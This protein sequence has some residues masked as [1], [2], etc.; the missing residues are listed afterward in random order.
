[1]QILSL[2]KNLN[3]VILCDYGFSHEWMSFVCWY[4][5]SKN[6]PDAS[7]TILCN[8]KQMTHNL[9][10]WTKRCRVRL[11]LHKD[12]DLEPRIALM[13][14]LDLKKPILI[15]DPDT[16]CVR[17]FDETKIDLNLLQEIILANAH[18]DIQCDCKDS[19]ISLFASYQKGWGT[20]VCSN[21]IDNSSCPLISSL[22]FGSSNMTINESRTRNLW[23]SAVY[24]F[25]NV[26]R[27]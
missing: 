11:V 9:F 24:L 2:G 17:D 4:S 25:N 3:I 19:E 6:L 5:I 13:H 7:V 15:V 8:R 20:F 12:L 21:W 26:S 27:G 16:V 14:Q 18:S 10:S 23:N 1:M 22:D